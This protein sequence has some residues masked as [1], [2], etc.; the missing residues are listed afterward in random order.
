MWILN[1]DPEQDKSFEIFKRLISSTPIIKVINESLPVT[2]QSDNSKDG[3]R[4][5]L[6]QECHP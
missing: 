2:L 6:L 4:E 1:E 3:L 5:W